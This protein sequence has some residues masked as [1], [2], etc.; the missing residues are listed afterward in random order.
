MNVKSPLHSLQGRLLIASAVILPIVL[1]I[2]GIALSKAYNYSL[3][4][5]VNDRLQLQVYLL[6]GAVELK[7]DHIIF[8]ERLQ[9]PR[10]EQVN[11]G[12]YAAIHDQDG[13]LLWR[14]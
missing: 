5:A 7:E 13:K 4:N 14:S 8:P 12:L 10:Y 3:E 11:S 6:L 1:L 9:E 2:A